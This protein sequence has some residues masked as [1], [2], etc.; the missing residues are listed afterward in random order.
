MPARPP[1]KQG[2][3]RLNARTYDTLAR[4]LRTLRLDR[5]VRWYTSPSPDD[6]N[7]LFLHDS[8]TST[9]RNSGINVPANLRDLVEKHIIPDLLKRN[10]SLLEELFGK[11]KSFKFSF[12]VVNDPSKTFG[13][14]HKDW[15]DARHRK[16]FT[17][18][19][20]V[21][22]TYFKGTKL[23]LPVKRKGEVFV[24]YWDNNVEHQ[25]GVDPVA[26]RAFLT[27]GPEVDSNFVDFPPGFVL[28]CEGKTAGG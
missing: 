4:I 2:T 9:R 27:C 19:L 16:F 18:S 3:L 15:D 13:N 26:M 10:K 17:A 21:P 5:N 1:P 25:S 20:G 23:R 6:R 22:T 11:R 14:L 28:S 8:S 7:F 24:H 12:F